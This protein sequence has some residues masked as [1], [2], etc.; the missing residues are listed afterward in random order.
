MFLNGLGCFLS[1]ET[2]GWR[3]KVRERRLEKEGWRKKVRER[4]L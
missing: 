4:R 3:N 2:E 1:L